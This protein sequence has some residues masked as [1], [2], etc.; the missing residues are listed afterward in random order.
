MASEKKN[1]VTPKGELQWVVVNGQGK[2]NYDGDG[3]E[4]TASII[5]T[6]EEADEFQDMVDDYY[7]EQGGQEETCP[8]KIIRED[9]EGNLLVTFK[10]QAEFE[11]RPVKVKIVDAYNKPVHLPDDVGI[12]NG[13]IGKISGTLS[14]FK[15]KKNDGV[16]LFLKSIKINKFVKYIAETGFEDD[17]DTDGGFSGFDEDT[18]LE[19][20]EKPKR[21]SR[22]RN[23]DDEDN[24]TSPARSSRRSRRSRR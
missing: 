15:R 19:Q 12:G 24:K 6:E 20:A 3:Y 18:D 21:P 9:K 10:T 22:Q 13:S 23:N 17:D 2:E 7:A 14:Y 11:G 1:V 8:T 16:S 4:Y 5:L